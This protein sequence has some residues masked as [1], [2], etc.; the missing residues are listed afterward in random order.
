M[1]KKTETK[2]KEKKPEQKPM[3]TAHHPK[4]YGKKLPQKKTMVD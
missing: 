4:K 1:E 2:K 3:F